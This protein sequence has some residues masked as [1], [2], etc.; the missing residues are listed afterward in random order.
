MR[1]W[2][3][4]GEGYGQLGDSLSL[5]Q[6]ECPFCE[7]QGNFSLEHHAQKKKTKR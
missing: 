6:V 1:S 7:E 4:L 2:W 3:D 5:Y